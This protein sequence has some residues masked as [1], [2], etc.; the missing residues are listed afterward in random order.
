[1]ARQAK[2]AEQFC[3]AEPTRLTCSAGRFG[4]VQSHVCLRRVVTSRN[5][6]H[7]RPMHTKKPTIQKRAGF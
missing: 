7:A 4:Y 6:G 2:A 5:A 3:A 1:M